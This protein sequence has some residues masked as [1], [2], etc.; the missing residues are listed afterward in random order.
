MELKGKFFDGKISRSIDSYL[1]FSEY[2]INVNSALSEELIR[3]PVSKVKINKMIGKDN[4]QFEFSGGEI[5]ESTD[6]VYDEYY[7]L[8]KQMN[9]PNQVIS[10]LEKNSFVS[11]IA[12]IL[13]AFSMF[14]GYN[15]GLP[16]IAKTAAG[17]IP[18]EILNEVD[19]QSVNAINL[20]YV[21]DS[22]LEEEEQD[23]ISELFYETADYLGDQDDYELIFKS[24]EEI[25][26]NAFALPGGTI[27]ITDDLVKMAINLEDLQGIFAHEIAH[28]NYRHGIRNI[29]QNTGVFLIFSAVLGDYSSL[30]S[31]GGALPMLLIESG[32][33]RDF[34]READ[35][36]AA[37]YLMN[38]KGS[39][40]S[41]Q[42]MLE[43]LSEDSELRKKGS[44]ISTH[45]GSEERIELVKETEKKFNNK[46]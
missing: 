36:F 24:S 25:G 44:V 15:W 12:L 18:D 6:E 35:I 19:E 26:A 38:T 16:E 37:E 28:V 30:A 20:F 5:F 4:L 23:K 13:V 22:E 31:A 9:R 27:I 8:Q 32:Y 34:E 45:P 46:F 17:K 43:K 33:S 2:Y 42:T 40:I 39:T 21:Q 7:E 41:Y 29:I 14:A 10:F 11:Y 1:T 3:E